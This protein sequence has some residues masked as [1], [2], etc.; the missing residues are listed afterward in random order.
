[1]P[2]SHSTG[3]WLW[4]WEGGGKGSPVPAG[5]CEAHGTCPAE[6]QGQGSE[7]AAA[8]RG[9]P[10]LS[11]LLVAFEAWLVPA[12]WD[13]GGCSPALGS[14]L[15]F[16]QFSVV[17]LRASCFRAG[18]SRMVREMSGRPEQAPLEKAAQVPS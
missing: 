5:G 6:L 15:S 1:M 17:G 14:L 18:K 13:S 4:G 2:G 7:P 10:A 11:Q 3:S 12:G 8:L 16:L 9:S